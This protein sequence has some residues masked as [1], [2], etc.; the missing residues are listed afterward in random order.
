ML[1]K[2]DVHYINML[3]EIA[4][5]LGHNTLRCKHSAALVIKNK[6]VSIGVN[7][8]KSDP[9]QHKYARKKLP[10]YMNNWLHAE[11][12]CLKN[13]NFDPKKATLY[14]VRANNQGK[15]MESCP[16]AGCKKL[17]H[18]VKISRIVYSISN[19]IKE[20]LYEY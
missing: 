2:T 9:F 1:K 3:R 15:L 18:D 7:K 19:G 16:C 5:N 14:V 8:E 12:D 4:Q 6:L 20:I 11:V 10:D 13:V 17:I